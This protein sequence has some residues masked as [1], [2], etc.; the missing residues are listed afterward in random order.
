MARV[1]YCGNKILCRT[2]GIP[3][4][5][6]KGLII[7]MIY[8]GEGG[9]KDTVVSKLKVLWETFFLCPP[10]PLSLSFFPKVPSAL[11]WRS[12]D[13]WIEGPDF[14][15]SACCSL[16]VSPRQSSQLS[17]KETFVTI[18]IEA[19]LLLSSHKFLGSIH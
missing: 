4:C 5:Q 10:P 7:R 11:A 8:S 18:F 16:A 17:N 13:T 6:I 3:K 2:F 19:T 1:E 14:P 15:P 9:T 12:V